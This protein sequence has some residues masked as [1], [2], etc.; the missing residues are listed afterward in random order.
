[1]TAPND[2]LR[3]ML[4]T[5]GMSQAELARRVKRRAHEI[6][7]AQVSPDAS[8]VRRWMEGMTPR[9]PLPVI[10]ADVFSGHC[11]RRVTTYDIGLG[12]QPDL[13]RSLKYNPS[14]KETVE[15][16]TE[17]G[18]ADM[19]RRHVLAA[20]PFTVAAGVGPSRDWLLSTLDQE[21]KPASGQRL[22]VEDVTHVRNMFGSFQEIDVMQGGGA[23]RKLL[24]EY[25][26]EH[27]YPLLRRTYSKEVYRAL[28]AAI[29][30]QTYLLGWMAFDNG[31]HA[32]AQRYLIQSLRMA[33][34]SQDAALGAHVLAGMAD[35][36]TLRGNPAEGRRLAQTGRHGL[37]R[38]DAPSCLA[39]LWVLEARAL[40]ALGDKTG[41]ARAVAASERAFDR[42]DSERDRPT[43]AKFI[44]GAYLHGEMAN[45]FRDLKQPDLAAVHASR[46]IEHARKQ[47]R[48]RRGAMSQA[49]L[50]VTHLQ[51]G[52]LDAAHSAAVKTIDLAR[53]VKSSRAVEALQDV[54]KRMTPFGTHPL[55]AD[56][57]ER[58]RTLLA[59]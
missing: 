58:A 37:A 44:D 28:T 24:K 11:D 34:E 7:H 32:A 41:T 2:K 38:V 29:C 40:A 1:M 26:N 4:L 18:R 57:N 48:A 8:S 56:F 47:N 42:A 23:G 51:K 6:G 54:R 49:A 45:A 12:D 55:V 36:A 14:W 25:M 9:A 21:P 52:D 33:E 59:A 53:R 5:A 50:A 13:D 43:W 19:D 15:A 16:V 27:V 22:R 17:L 46:S 20:L 35:Q 30:E 31:E 39:D 3:D 10:I